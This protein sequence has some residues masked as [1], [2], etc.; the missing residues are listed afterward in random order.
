MDATIKLKV[1][2]SNIMPKL[3]EI[4]KAVNVLGEARL[5]NSEFLQYIKEH[6]SDH[7]A[8]LINVQIVG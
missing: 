6:I 3:E 7:A 2:A 4:Q 5:L 8:S 1:D